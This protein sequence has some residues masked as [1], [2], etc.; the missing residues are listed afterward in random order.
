MRVYG[1]DF[2][3]EPSTSTPLS[4]AMCRL[5]GDELVLDGLCEF[6]SMD[7]FRNLLDMPGPWVA[8]VDFPFGLPREFLGPLH[9]PAQ[10]E[11]YVSEVAVLRRSEFRALS[12][13]LQGAA[14]VARRVFRRRTDGTASDVPAP[15]S[16]SGAMFH[17]GA[18]VLLSSEVSVL[19]VRH[20]D[21]RRIVVEAAPE[22]VAQAMVGGR[23]YK[24]AGA[25]PAIG[26]EGRNVRE[27]L[28]D[29]LCSDALFER[30]GISV[31]AVGA[32]EGEML[33]DPRGDRVDALMCAVQAAWAWQR[34]D[35]GFG[36]PEDAD[37]VEGCIADPAMVAPA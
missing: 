14:C 3:P 21:E 37:T 15:G 7:S 9:W 29:A 36:L 12:E 26:E 35:H 24:S 32:L 6:E 10:W 1:I 11:R 31:A 5:V 34:R 8:G 33:D 2:S 16:S 19:P 23:S 25:L 28:L 4:C 30:Y 20:G 17:A 18:P 27:S 22:L 13:A